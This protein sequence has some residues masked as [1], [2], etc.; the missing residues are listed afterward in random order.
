[1]A[2]VLQRYRSAKVNVL[3]VS[4]S[5]RSYVRNAYN[6]NQAKFMHTI[7][8]KG[9]LKIHWR[10]SYCHN[11]CDFPRSKHVRQPGCIECKGTYARASRRFM[12]R[13]AREEKD[14]VD[15]LQV[16]RR[17]FVAYIRLVLAIVFSRLSIFFQLVF[18]FQAGFRSHDVTELHDN[19]VSLSPT[20]SC[21]QK[22]V[23]DCPP[24][25][26]VNWEW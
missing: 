2:I 14:A 8:G 3:L 1:M 25:R 22:S 16:W 13:R 10:R 18:P 4:T 7:L 17:Q 26:E 9:S 24:A 5:S 21:K 23:L 19:R 15:F 20:M 6:E 11:Q 12:S